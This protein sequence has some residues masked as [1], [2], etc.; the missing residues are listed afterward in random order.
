MAAISSKALKPF[1]AENKYKFNEGT[2]VANKEFSDGSG[3]EMYETTYRGYDPQI[4]RFMQLDQL[5]DIDE[6][7]SPYSFSN[8]NPIL[9]NDPLGLTGDTADLAPVI[10]G[11]ISSFHKKLPIF[12]P[13]RRIYF[14]YLDHS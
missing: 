8:D 1:Y 10:V 4:G 12:F 2:E 7:Y 11:F 14:Q 13:L 3:L 6:S 5:A 9:L